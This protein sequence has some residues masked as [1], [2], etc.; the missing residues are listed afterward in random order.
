MLAKA[1]ERQPDLFKAHSSQLYTAL[2]KLISQN[3]I[4]EAEYLVR[5]AIVI[6][7][8]LITQLD[9]L[10]HMLIRVCPSLVDAHTRSHFCKLIIS[11]LSYALVKK[12]PNKK[13]AV[14]LFDLLVAIL[15][16]C[17]IEAPECAYRMLD[18]SEFYPWKQLGEQLTH[19]VR[20]CIAY[21][22]IIVTSLS[23]KLDKLASILKLTGERSQANPT[24]LSA[25]REAALEAV[26]KWSSPVNVETGQLYQKHV[27]AMGEQ[28]TRLIDNRQFSVEFCSK[29]L[30]VVQNHVAR[31]DD[32][33]YHVDESYGRF[34]IVSGSIRD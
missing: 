12:K 14:T 19:L 17:V 23:C 1:L 8:D 11:P 24:V 32:P 13:V 3:N 22:Q 6:H 30:A 28:M 16:L 34:L 10:L 25:T 4:K 31:N 9:E 7:F 20:S 21:D 18:I 26:M 5:Y 27:Y 2:E 33:T 15:D 29:L